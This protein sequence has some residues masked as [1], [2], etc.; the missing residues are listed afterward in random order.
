MYTPGEPDDGDDNGDDD[1]E[2]DT[3]DTEER[4]LRVTVD[5]EYGESVYFTGNTAELTEWNGGIEGTW[6]EG[7]VWEVTVDAD[8]D[9]EWKTRRG[10][11]DDTGDVWERGENH[12]AAET[13]PTHQGWEDE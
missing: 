12:T 3:G 10:P 4:T 7:N 1:D 6:T 2:D 13:H 11:T 8:D 5:V 9:L